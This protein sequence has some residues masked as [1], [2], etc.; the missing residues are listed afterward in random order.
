MTKSTYNRSMDI[1]NQI[2]TLHHELDELNINL[3]TQDR[4]LLQERGHACIIKTLF[5]A[6]RKRFGRKVTLKNGDRLLFH[7]DLEDI[8]CLA[9][10]RRQKIS[11]LQTEMVELLDGKVCNK[12]ESSG[13]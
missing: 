9:D 6:T 4:A 12:C 1:V 7:L 2:Y 11:E 5:K 13:V 8:R 3:T 10:R